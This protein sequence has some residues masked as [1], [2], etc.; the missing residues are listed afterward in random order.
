M[1]RNILE[2]LGEFTECEL[3]K[4]KILR[5]NKDYNTLLGNRSSRH[6]IDLMREKGVTLLVGKLRDG[7]EDWTLAVNG[8]FCDPRFKGQYRGNV[9]ENTKNIFL[10][11]NRYSN[12]YFRPGVKGF[13][14]D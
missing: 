4:R 12:T 13:G 3:L 2:F 9:F 11:R 8:D 1:T 5:K 6:L 14:R 10:W 7:Q